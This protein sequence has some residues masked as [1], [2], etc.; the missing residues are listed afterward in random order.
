MDY[1]IAILAFLSIPLFFGSMLY[2]FVKE[3]TLDNDQSDIA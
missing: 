2:L 1:W 3:D